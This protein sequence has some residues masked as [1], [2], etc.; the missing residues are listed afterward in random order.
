MTTTAVLQALSQLTE[1]PLRFIGR[2]K[3]NG[4]DL[5]LAVGKH[6]LFLLDEKLHGVIRGGR[7][8]YAHIENVVIDTVSKDLFQINTNENR[9][10][11]CLPVM[12]VESGER[13]KL[14]KYAE[15]CW[16][17][18]FMFRMNKVAQF[19][20]HI[21]RVRYRGASRFSNLFLE[22]PPAYRKCN[23]RGYFF[24]VKE[25]YEEMVNELTGMSLGRYRDKQKRE[26]SV[27]VG[28]AIPVLALDVKGKTDLKELARLAIVARAKEDLDF[29]ITE[30][31]T[32]T[33]K[34]NL[35]NDP[36]SWTCWEMHVRTDKR[37]LGV[38]YARRKYIPPLM[39]ACQDMIVY[40]FGPV[41]GK[42]GGQE[43]AELHAVMAEVVDTLCPESS[44]PLWD[45]IVVQARADALLLD[46]ETYNWYQNRL[47]I[48][49][50]CVTEAQQFVKSLIYVMELARIPDWS[51]KSFFPEVQARKDPM[52]VIN[53]LNEMKAE[54]VIDDG[55]SESRQNWKR[56]VSEYFAFC[57]DG[58]LL[59]GRLSLANIISAVDSC[60]SAAYK[61]L[62]MKVLDYLL[63]LH[64]KD[65]N[66]F[67]APMAQKFGD[68]RLEDGFRFNEKVMQV[69][70]ETNYIKTQLDLTDDDLAFPRF[71]VL[72]MKKASNVSLQEAICR[73]F[74]K[75][76]IPVVAGEVDA[77]LTAVV[78]S[79]VD[80][81]NADNHSLASL[82][83]GALVNLSKNR[84]YMKNVIVNEGGIRIVIPYLSSRDEKLILNSCKLLLNCSKTE[85]HRDNIMS[86]GAV[87]LLIRLLQDSSVPGWQYSDEVVGVASMVIGNLAQDAN[88]RR[89]IF[90]FSGVL[91]T[92]IAVMRNRDTEFVK[93]QA[94]FALKQLLVR[95]SEGDKDRVGT[96]IIPLVIQM[97][98]TSNHRDLVRN[99]LAALNVMSSSHSMCLLMINSRIAEVLERFRFNKERDITEKVTSIDKYI[100]K[101]IARQENGL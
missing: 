44:S 16:K 36:A 45:K 24:F 63:Y 59:Y 70:L 18:D 91:D 11:N 2:V 96:Q 71:L 10:P 28:D 67:Y 72:L 94:L 7:I 81:L 88:H 14:L 51:A 54:G 35:T 101:A 27:K 6:A 62:L 83:A 40:A 58:G 76:E 60:D 78:P 98:S 86:S 49:P 46:W 75:A 77:S 31:R 21:T 100:R 42:G 33:K 95:Q 89:T 3:V 73:Q 99:G 90:N 64:P 12:F 19:P 39:D 53:E 69:Y 29:R 37:E 26:V 79:L 47:S 23:Y 93:C 32:Y 43:A 1:E 4:V 15:V 97:L 55:N 50:K 13:D 17:T 61:T 48:M 8:Y 41:A 38:I 66:Y 92:I 25:A 65:S 20:F 85:N 34:A 30:S 5:Y 74:I 87:S 52:G 80:L 57:V 82:A 22:P 84:D 68:R 56:K 9:P